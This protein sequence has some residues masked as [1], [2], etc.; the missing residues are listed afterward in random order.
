[1]PLPEAE[2][3][4]FKV[5]GG[6]KYSYANN[7]GKF[8]A[9]LDL[10]TEYVVSVS[11]K[12]YATRTITVLT[13]VPEGTNGEYT[14]TVTLDLQKMRSDLKGNTIREETAGGVMFNEGSVLS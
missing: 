5:D 1:M 8:V 6:L 7:V 11:E 4:I 14:Q 3:K 12:G 2:I 9:T 13:E 10:G